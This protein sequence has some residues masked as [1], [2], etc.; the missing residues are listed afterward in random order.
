[1]ITDVYTK[2]KI[3]SDMEG[4][5]GENGFIQLNNFLSENY[6]E[7]RENLIKENFVSVYEPLLCK[8]KILNLKE[9]YNFEIL[10]VIEFFKSKE[11]LNF[12]EEI[13]EFEVSL[14]KFEVNVYS[15]RDFVVLNNDVKNDENISIIYDVSDEFKEDMG[16][17]L[18]FVT[19]EEEV[20]CLEPS[21]NSLSIFYNPIE[22]S[23]YLKY[24]NN[25][26]K[27]LNIIRIEMEFS[28]IEL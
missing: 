24:I 9:T 21:F 20:F 7:F 12:I 10:R 1:M 16:G 13:T 4:F 8:K 25:R 11:F 19:K 26:S 15:H 27:G 6:K 2:K 28:I 17:V 18:T 3:I 23:K 5:F 14:T 22:I